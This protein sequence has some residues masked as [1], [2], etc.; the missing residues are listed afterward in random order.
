[1]LQAQPREQIVHADRRD[2]EAQRDAAG[3][4]HR[5]AHPRMAISAEHMVENERGDQIE[6]EGGAEDQRH[7]HAVPGRFG[8]HAALGHPRLA[9]KRP[10]PQAADREPRDR[11][12]QYRQPVNLRSH[13]PSPRRYG[14]GMVGCAPPLFYRTENH[15]VRS[16]PWLLS[17]PPRRVSAWFRS[18]VPRIWST[19]NASSPS[20][21]RTAIRCRRTM[22]VPT[23]CWSTHAVFSIPP[24]KKASRRSAR[25][26]PR[27]AASST[28]A[29]WF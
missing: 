8:R 1:M 16:I 4:H 3:D 5:K 6:H 9:E 22:P 11:G 17:F 28:P 26:S 23:S 14:A 15:Y 12:D 29:A 13:R 19:A 10:V 27:M 24:R 18:A 2:D 20:C 25:R 21:A 7:I